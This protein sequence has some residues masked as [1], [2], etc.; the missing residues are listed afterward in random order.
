MQAERG[1]R[2]EIER[3]HAHGHTGARTWPRVREG[4]YRPPTL[5]SLAPSV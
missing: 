3:A 4:N 1:A 5:R 2:P